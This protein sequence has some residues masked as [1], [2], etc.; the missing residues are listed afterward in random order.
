MTKE[1]LVAQLADLDVTDQEVAHAQAD[2][3]LLLYINDTEIDAAYD[4]IPKWYA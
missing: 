2:A 4:A 1:E 3:L